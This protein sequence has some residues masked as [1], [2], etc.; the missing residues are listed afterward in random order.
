MKDLQAI[1]FISG[2]KVSHDYSGTNVNT[3]SYRELVSRN[4]ECIGIPA[5]QNGLLII[6]IDVAGPSHQ[7]DGREWWKAFLKEK[8]LLTPTYTVRSPS[9]GYHFYYRLPDWVNP[10]TFTPPSQ[11][12][13][14][15]DI[16]YNGWVG[17]PPSPGYDIEYGT[18]ADILEAPRPLLEY[19]ADLIND[20]PM[21]TFDGMTIPEMHRPYTPKQIE[22]LRGKL[23]WM[24]QNATL[25]Y[26]EWRD[27]LF[28]MK[29]GIE[30]HDILNEF[31]DLWTMGKSYQPGD[32]HKARDIVEKASAQGGVGPGTLLNLCQQHMQMHKTVATDTPFTVQEILD[33]S[34]VQLS[35]DKAGMVQ[36]YP[37]ENNAAD[38]IGA[39]FDV[40]DLYHDVRQDLYIFKGQPASDVDIVNKLIPMIQS[41]HEGLGLQKLKKGLIAHGLD[42]LMSRRQVDPH[43]QYLLG[44]TWDG[45]PRVEQFFTR[46]CGVKDTEYVRIVSKNF[47]VSLAARGIKPGTKVDS[48]VVLEGQE[49]INKSSLIEAIAGE[50]T[51]APD[52]RDGLENLDILRQMH[53]SVITELPELMGILHQPAE[54]VKAFL[55]NRCD[56]IRALFAKKAMKNMRG[57]I[58]VGTTNSSRYLSKAAGLRRFWPIRIP[59]SKRVDIAALRSDRD[60]LYAEAVHL[61][62]NGAEWWHVPKEMLEAET[63]LRVTQEP[64]VGP[65]KDMAHRFGMGWTISE[66]YTELE[67]KGFMRSGLTMENVERIE[68]ALRLAGCAESD[69]DRGIVWRKPFDP[70]MFEAHVGIESFI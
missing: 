10:D 13:P 55:S 25:S 48:M 23:E 6:D 14:G 31:I 66:V 5:R 19:I 11:L 68:Y 42:I 40:K 4:I 35:F 38:L 18:L 41:P 61:F 34:G 45:V 22:D 69:S 29:A 46:Y 26:S 7:Q 56:T 51:Y 27:G 9:G 67:S 64:L 63:G 53:Q 15:V 58:F 24:K 70:A 57:F 3:F 44:L 43:K 52:S 20:R 33:R 12:A 28:A 54:K 36:V 32:E 21:K 2:T 60:Q 17:A 65:I 8:N 1:R 16:K 50:Y 37:S 39:I 30:D 59:D 62:R 49:G 47:W